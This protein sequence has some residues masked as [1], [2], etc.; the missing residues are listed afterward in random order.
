MS[1]RPFS[2]GGVGLR[3]PVGLVALL[4]VAAPAAAADC[5]PL[6]RQLKLSALDQM[7]GAVL[8]DAEKLLD[9]DSSA[10]QAR[11]YRARALDRL[12]KRAEAVTAYEAFMAKD[13]RGAANEFLC[14]D[15]RV[16][17]TSLLK[18]RV[19]SEGC[20]SEA[21]D[22]LL[23]G[24]S[25]GDPYARI[26]TAME[27][28]KLPRCDDA[29]AKALKVLLEAQRLE[30]DTEFR[31]EICLAI[32]RIDPSKCSGGTSKNAAADGPSFIKVRV[33]DCN[34]E[35][36]KVSV[37]MP[38]SFARAVME[39]LGPEILDQIKAEGFDI[40]NLWDSISK[41]G[42][43][44]KFQFKIDDDHRCEEIEVWFE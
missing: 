29:K 16:S 17:H 42:P 13:C 44:Q 39:S 15:A 12:R 8:E 23:S 4:A 24:L 20:G 9:C 14:E 38:F 5:A 26:F 34:A 10:A 1:D 6:A 35:R 7:W 21:M 3:I 41:L 43:D 22:Q 32:I 30:D 11:F 33:F 2:S 40:E 36:V 18:E 19:T 25:T 37:N 31:N 27:L 28:S